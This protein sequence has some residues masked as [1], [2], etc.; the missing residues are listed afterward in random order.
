MTVLFIFILF[1]ISGLLAA[2]LLTSLKKIKTNEEEAGRN[3]VDLQNRVDALELQTGMLQ[4][5]CQRLQ[6]QLLDISS[7]IASAKATAKDNTRD[8]NERTTPIQNV[9][10]GYLSN[11]IQSGNGYFR[12]LMPTADYTSKFI[13]TKAEEPD[14]IT[15][16]PIDLKTLRSNDGLDR[17]VHITGDIPV[18]EAT[19]F[20]VTKPGRAKFDGDRWN[21][22]TPCQIYYV[23]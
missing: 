17:A 5:D 14:T 19:G 21:I 9:G 20:G 10:N 2:K 12:E 22:V 18:E 16:E 15:F 23:R 7:R 13:A 4:T 11:V 1:L 8:D 6:R 3:I